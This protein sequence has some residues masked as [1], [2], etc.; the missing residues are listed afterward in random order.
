MPFPFRSPWS[1]DSNR[2]LKMPLIQLVYIVDRQAFK[3]SLFFHHIFSLCLSQWIPPLVMSAS[4]K[5][6]TALYEPRVGYCWKSQTCHSWS[7]FELHVMQCVSTISS[8]SPIRW[9]VMPQW[10]F[11]SLTECPRLC[12]F[13]N[14]CIVFLMN[15]FLVSVLELNAGLGS[16]RSA[17]HANPSDWQTKER[18]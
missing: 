9:T 13:H 15:V 10:L 12:W 11:P 3:S 6:N 16:Y 18:I 5:K 1:N 14:I 17:A 8:L 2:I 7:V 4:L